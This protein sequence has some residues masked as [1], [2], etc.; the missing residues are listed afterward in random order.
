MTDET[1]NDC[2]DAAHSAL[3]EENQRLRREKAEFAKELTEY[4]AEIS[5]ATAAEIWTTIVRMIDMGT[6][7]S[8]L[9]TIASMYCEEL[10][11][12]APTR[13]ADADPDISGVPV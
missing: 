6:P 1:L 13:P 4:G 11:A 10:A 12:T 2:I 9:R 7:R 5:R 8:G 3:A